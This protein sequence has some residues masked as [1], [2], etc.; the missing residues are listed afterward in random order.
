MPAMI[1]FSGML[2]LFRAR[3]DEAFGVVVIDAGAQ[4]V[5]AG[6]D[7][8]ALGQRRI[9]AALELR[10]HRAPLFVPRIRI[11]LPH[12][13]PFTN[14]IDLLERDH[15]IGRHALQDQGCIGPKKV[16]VEMIDPWSTGHE[17]SFRKL[18][19]LFVHRWLACGRRQAG[20]FWRI[21]I[22]SMRLNEV[23]SACSPAR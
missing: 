13:E 8:V 12:P 2:S 17:K 7:L 18:V 3:R 19:D 15:A 11:A 6:A 20:T 16:I 9:G 1:G 4:I 23:V 22:A 5:V 21:V 10:A 14:A